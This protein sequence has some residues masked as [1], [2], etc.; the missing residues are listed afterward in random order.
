MSRKALL[1]HIRNTHPEDYPYDKGGRPK[2]EK[3]DNVRD[4]YAGR[5]SYLFIEQEEEKRPVGRPRKRKE[6]RGRPKN[7]V[8]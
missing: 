2:V 8:K 1:K 7:I 3:I 6:T 4:I 5:A